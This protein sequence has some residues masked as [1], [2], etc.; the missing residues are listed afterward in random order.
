METL[1]RKLIIA[2]VGSALLL[3]GCAVKHKRDADT[4]SIIQAY[5]DQKEQVK[6][7]YFRALERLPALKG[8][9][10]LAWVV[11]GKGVL[12]KAWIKDSSLGD[13]DMESCILDHLKTVSFPRTQSLAQVTVEYTL[14]FSR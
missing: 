2:V 7:C 5:R 6:N 8:D 13:A 12:K 11:D 1:G 4:E 9:V 14:N 10:T 3:S